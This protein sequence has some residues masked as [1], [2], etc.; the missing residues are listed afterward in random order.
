MATE[1]VTLTNRTKRPP[2]MLVLNLDITVASE[3]I[4]RR[5]T[6]EGK[7]GKRRKKPVNMSVPKSLRILPGEKSA[8]VPCSYLRCKEVAAAVAARD[9]LVKDWAK[10]VP[11][12]K[13][14]PKPEPEPEP[15]VKPEPKPKKRTAKKAD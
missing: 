14:E 8:P 4:Q 9:I 10:P 13:P 15:E 2:R 7:D 11:E 12:V 5:E 6:V 3:R 1:K